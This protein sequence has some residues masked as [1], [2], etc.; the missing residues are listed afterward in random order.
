MGRSIGGQYSSGILLTMRSSLLVPARVEF[1]MHENFSPLLSHPTDFSFLLRPSEDINTLI[2]RI[3]YLSWVH[4]GCVGFGGLLPEQ[5]VVFDLRSRR[6]S[7]S[8]RVLVPFL[9]SASFLAL[10]V[11]H[12]LSVALLRPVQSLLLSS[13]VTLCPRSVFQS[14]LCHRL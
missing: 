7:L 9:G 8:V 12:A 10:V 1:H 2:S 3:C 4:S 13:Q 14:L 11:V 6:S 5:N